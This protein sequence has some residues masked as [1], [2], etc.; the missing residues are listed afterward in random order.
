ML[1]SI[2]VAVGGVLDGTPAG[3]DDSGVQDGQVAIGL[4]KNVPF[5]NAASSPEAAVALDGR[6]AIAVKTKR[7][8]IPTAMTRILRFIDCTKTCIW[9][10]RFVKRSPIE[11]NPKFMP[12][13]LRDE[14]T[15]IAIAGA[16]LCWPS[17]F[18]GRH[19][20]SIR[21]HYEKRG[22]CS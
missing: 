4:P 10:I 17:T 15:G 22:G 5:Q 14:G 20:L 21:L 11:V 18:R 1:G 8:E 3:G 7:K 19:V 16:F 2:S 12:R 6:T 9:V 13:R